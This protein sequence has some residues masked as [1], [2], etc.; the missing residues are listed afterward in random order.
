MSVDQDFLT[1]KSNAL[2]SILEDVLVQSPE[3]N[4][5]S[6][7]TAIYG[8]RV[9][10]VL[11]PRM[12]VVDIWNHNIFRAVTGGD[13]RWIEFLI[14]VVVA[15]KNTSDSLKEAAE[16]LNM[17]DTIIGNTLRDSENRSNHE[18]KDLM[19]VRP[20]ARPPAPKEYINSRYSL[21]LLRM[22]IDLI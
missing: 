13:G 21:T 7:A 1:T 10:Q 6:P 8:Y 12:V 2:V 4:L 14:H 16:K 11:Q 17:I 3:S 22:Q 5:D 20:V 19:F 15:H 9:F 18:W